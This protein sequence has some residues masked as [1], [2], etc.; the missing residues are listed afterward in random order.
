M[1]RMRGSLAMLW[2]Y[3]HKI[4]DDLWSVHLS[5]STEFLFLSHLF[6]W[7]LVSIF[8]PFYFMVV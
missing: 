1:P 2:I 3:K 5:S 8:L 7:S 4:L 6:S